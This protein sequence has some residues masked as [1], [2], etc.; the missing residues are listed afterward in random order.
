MCNGFVS[1]IFVA[2]IRTIRVAVAPVDTLDALVPGDAFELGRCA[3]PFCLCGRLCRSR[4][5]REQRTHTF[6]YTDT[7][8][9]NAAVYTGNF[10]FFFSFQFLAFFNSGGQGGH[11]FLLS[12]Q[13]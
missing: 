13:H 10:F 11:T 3:F 9:M 5:T 12:F 6:I 2:V 1:A 4:N 7:S 8:T